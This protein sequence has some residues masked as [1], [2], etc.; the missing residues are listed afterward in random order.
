M[1][2]PAPQK[3]APLPLDYG[4]WADMSLEGL[5]FI[6]GCLTRDYTQRMTVDEALDHPWWAGLGRGVVW[7]RSRDLGAARRA[8]SGGRSDPP[9]PRP[10]CPL[11]T[12]APLSPLHPGPSVPSPPRPLC[13][14]S[15]PAPLS[16]LHPVP[17]PRHPAIHPVPSPRH[18]ATPP[19][20]QN[21]RF[22]KWLPDEEEVMAAPSTSAVLDASEAA[23]T[24]SSRAGPLDSIGSSAD[25]AT[26]AHRAH[27]AGQRRG[28]R[29]VL[30]VPKHPGAGQQQQQQQ[31]LQQQPGGHLPQQAQPQHAA[32]AQ[33]QQHQQQAGHNG[34][35]APRRRGPEASADGAPAPATAGSVDGGPKAAKRQKGA[36]SLNVL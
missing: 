34:G 35:A 23:S 20:A 25:E 30:V 28:E 27:I 16:P 2:R 19:P 17:S 3:D 9:P 1:D 24:A 36:S 21:P 31:Q 6:R 18:S 22:D 29:Q 26:E 32:G 13:P 10:L 11:S 8:G 12:P 4:P 14:L 15:T 33:A 7:V 5:A